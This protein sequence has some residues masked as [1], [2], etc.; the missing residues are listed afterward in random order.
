MLNKHPQTVLRQPKQSNLTASHQIKSA[1][2]E[3]KLLPPQKQPLL[4]GNKFTITNS[5]QNPTIRLQSSIPVTQKQELMRLQCEP[6][7]FQNLDKQQSQLLQDK[8]LSTHQ[9]QIDEN[10]GDWQEEVYQKVQGLNYKYLNRLSFTYAYARRQLKQLLHEGTNS[11]EIEK[12][13]ALL[14]KLEEIFK[15]LRVS[16]THITL[17]FDLDQVERRIVR[18]LKAVHIQRMPF[19]SHNQGQ[20]SGDHSM[21]QSNNATTPS[22]PFVI[23][24]PMMTTSPLLHDLSQTAPPPSVPLDIST[25]MMTMTTSPLLLEESQQYICDLSQTAPPQSI[26]VIS[27]PMMTMTTSPLLE[28]QQVSCDF[29]QTT[30]DESIAVEQP[31]DRLIRLV[32]TM[33]PQAL[34]AS[35]SDIES[36]VY[37]ADRIPGPAPELLSGLRAWQ[38]RDDP[39]SRA[40]KMRRFFEATPL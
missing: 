9:L 40:P 32:N 34:R 4:E 1:I 38:Y 13:G 17:G 33:S 3:K 25:P 30:S 10:I 31:I 15:Q 29:N 12:Y 37:M 5:Q 23:Y 22:E 8:N 7:Q 39:P 6:S 35:V 24:T 2:Q 21:Q 36:V 20:D 18:I 27:T 26:P 14:N 11:T 28:E 19:L 16:K